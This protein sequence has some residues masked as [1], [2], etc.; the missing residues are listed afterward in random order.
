MYAVKLNKIL[1]ITFSYP[2]GSGE[3][4]L[5][6]ELEFLSNNNV[7]VSIYPSSSKGHSREVPKNIE[8]L[9]KSKIQRWFI[10]LF[11]A[12]YSFFKYGKYYISDL[13]ESIYKEKLNIL[14][15]SRFA[16]IINYILRSSIYIAWFDFFYKKN[17]SQ[18]TLIYTYW[19]NSESYAVSILKRAN[20]HLKT[21]SRVHGGDLY[22][23][24]NADFLP[25]REQI[26]DSLDKIFTISNH[27]K[28]YLTNQY[29]LKNQSKIILSRLGVMKQ[30]RISI[31]ESSSEVVIA[32][33]SSDDSVKRIPEILSTLGYFS[34]KTK[35]KVIWLNIGIEKNI[36]YN[37]YGNTL[38]LYPNLECRILGILP[39]NQIGEEYKKFKPSLFI[40]LSSSE[41]VPVSIM[42]AFSFGIPVIATDVGGT[43]EIVNNSVG[44]LV[45]AI[46]DNKTIK[47]E[48]DRL[49]QS[50]EEYSFRA[51][52]Q[53]DDL[54]NSE[55]NY[56]RHYNLL[57]EV[58]ND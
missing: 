15:F 10:N 52:N 6:D 9:R 31:R 5:C 11:G 14:R 17:I 28:E 48:I 1:L 4:F 57:N 54:C 19:M 13:K 21:V 45:D 3:H 35:A 27:G 16:Y 18:T 33:C 30:Q 43:S 58:I 53:W 20:P 38:S 36:F 23:E 46:V 22:K 29:E 7:N 47:N 50:R 40:N 8:I 2:Y 49:I 24:R 32:S 56:N 55:Y 42:E 26:I 51:Y 44:S 39:N 25:Y 41:G 34:N 12:P 37:K